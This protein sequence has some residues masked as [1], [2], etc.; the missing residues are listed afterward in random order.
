[1]R[2]TKLSQCWTS[3]QQP[4]TPKLQDRCRAESKKLDQ[5][6]MPDKLVVT[7]CMPGEVCRISHIRS[8]APPNIGEI[9][10]A[11]M[12]TASY[13]LTLSRFTR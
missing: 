11:T 7:A 12:K 10:A 3:S 6:G 9:V 13:L 1:M 5:P 2:R 8:G 4:I